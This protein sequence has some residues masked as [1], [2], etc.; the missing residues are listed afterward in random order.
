MNDKPCTNC[1][2]IDDSLWG[3]EYPGSRR[4]E[5]AQKKVQQLLDFGITD[6]IDLTEPQEVKPYAPFL[7]SRARYHRF[8]IRDISVP[9]STELIL[10]IARI[11]QNVRESGGRVY[12]HC[13]GGVGR[14]GTVGA[15][16]LAW[17]YRLTDGNEILERLRM[18]I[19]FHVDSM[20][21]LNHLTNGLNRRVY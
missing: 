13:L 10:E 12:L 3:G 16:L 4:D 1:F 19:W 14:T 15:C 9:E 11:V 20:L 5:E 21:P 2:L 7:K 8:P 18:Q 17:R 6:F